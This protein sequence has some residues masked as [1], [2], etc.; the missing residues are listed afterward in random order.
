PLVKSQFAP[1]RTE[2]TQRALYF[3]WREPE[4]QVCA[5]HRLFLLAPVSCFP[6]LRRIS[7]SHQ[8]TASRPRLFAKLPTASRRRKHRPKLLA[9][10]RK[11]SL[12]IRRE[13]VVSHRPV[14]QG[15]RATNRPQ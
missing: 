4:R 11:C 7:S 9:I 15:N 10:T 6:M 13:S 12:N 5:N 3:P 2:L 1:E 8:P 14:C